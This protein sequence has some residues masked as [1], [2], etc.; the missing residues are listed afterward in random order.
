PPRPAGASP[1]RAARLYC[2]R[3]AVS[4]LRQPA[5]LVP[6]RP[7]MSSVVEKRSAPTES[8]QLRISGKD[9][10]LPLIVGTEQ[11]RGLDVSKLLA[12]TGCVT[13]DEGYANT[14]A[15]NSSI[16]F[17]DG[18]RGNLRYRGY[19]IEDLAANC[20][21]LEVA[22]LLIYG[23]LPNEEQLTTFRDTILRHTMLHEDMRKFY[24]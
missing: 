3:G 5:F 11:E 12:T 16:T 22:H 8:A 21:F 9:F 10:E 19:A 17:L 2:G 23:E 7:T 6:S 18:D 14:G 24:G 4:R 13:L 1:P 15:T 20:D